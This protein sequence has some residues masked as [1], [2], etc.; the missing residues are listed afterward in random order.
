[1]ERLLKRPVKCLGWGEEHML[2]PEKEDS[3]FESGASSLADLI[4]YGIL[5]LYGIFD[6]VH[7]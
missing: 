3:I 1:M 5:G 7:Y 6:S 2:G 4:R